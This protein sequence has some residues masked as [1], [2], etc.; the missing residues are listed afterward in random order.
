MTTVFIY[1]EMYDWTGKIKAVANV[2]ECK[3]VQ[4]QPNFPIF[5]PLNYISSA[6]IKK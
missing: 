4:E 3:R 5:S 1:T 2:T 6:A